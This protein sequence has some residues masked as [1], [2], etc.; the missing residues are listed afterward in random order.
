MVKTVAGFLAAAA[1]AAGGAG[2]S[3]ITRRLRI[4]VLIVNV[5]C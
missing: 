3:V 4:G 5:M 2:S 1:A